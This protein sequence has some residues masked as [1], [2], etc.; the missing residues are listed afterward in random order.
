MTKYT[1]HY[2][3]RGWDEELSSNNI[4]ELICKARELIKKNTGKPLIITNDKNEIARELTPR[5]HSFNESKYS[6]DFKDYKESMEE[7]KEW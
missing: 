2:L 3:Y 4:D 7:L 5:L 6:N 1:L